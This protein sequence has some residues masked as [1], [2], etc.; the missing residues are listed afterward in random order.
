MLFGWKETAAEAE[1]GEVAL[2]QASVEATQALEGSWG[3]G[4]GLPCIRPSFDEGRLG[5][6]YSH[7]ALTGCLA[8]PPPSHLEPLEFY[9]KGFLLQKKPRLHCWV[10]EPNP[11][12]G[13]RLAGGSLHN[14][15]WW[16]LRPPGTHITPP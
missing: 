13:V 14:W 16:V 7:P 1:W 15:V 5:A 2:A 9:V 4:P 8:P 3:Q 6:R 10:W 11:N 12:P